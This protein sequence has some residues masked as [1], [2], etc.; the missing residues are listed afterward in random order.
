MQLTQSKALLE[1]AERVIPA[2]VNS[3]VRAYRAVGGDPPF[4]ARASGARLFDCDGNEYVDYVGSWGPAILGHAA[5]PV[6]RA[7]EHAARAGLSF[8]APTELEVRFAEAIVE[9]YPSIQM[10]RS[11]SSGTEATMSA[12]R[13][14]RGFTHRDLIVKFDGG[15]HGHADALLVKAGSGA[16]TFGSPDSDGVPASMVASTVSL[17][18]NDLSALERL[19]DARGQ[20]VAAVIVEPVAGNMGCVPPVPGFL[21]GILAL[22]RAH[23][24]VSIFD[25]VMTGCRLAPGGAQER[26]GLSPDMTCLGKVIGGGM[27]LAAYGGRAEIMSRV[28]PLGPVYQAGTLSGNPVAVSA[29]L[30]TLGEL[31]PSVYELLEARGARLEEGLRRALGDTNVPGCVARVGSMLTLF[32]HPGPLRCYDD[33]LQTDRA[34]FAR[35]HRELL[36]RGI[37]WPASQFEAA[38]ISAAHSEADIDWTVEAARAALAAG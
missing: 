37:Y 19:F 27:P 33:V 10:L 13:V 34:R 2:G 23:G 6:V 14:A 21:E 28:A 1:R 31:T 35:W 20:E 29:G 8:G 25:E 7:V 5:A 36:E 24:A 3:P 32:F 9:R 16:A 22:C 12:L 18:Y 4:I 26:F 15:Y 38:F 17:P 11:V 30:A